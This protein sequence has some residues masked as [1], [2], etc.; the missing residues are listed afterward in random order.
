MTDPTNADLA[1]R[2]DQLVQVVSEHSEVDLAAHEEAAIGRAEVLA[3]ITKIESSVAPLVEGM[4][5]VITLGKFVKW[6]GGM[7]ASVAALFALFK[8]WEMKT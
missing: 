1:L 6:A 5:A 2:I 3:K 7:A 8:F 4:G